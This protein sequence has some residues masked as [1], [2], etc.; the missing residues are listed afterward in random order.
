MPQLDIEL[1]TEAFIRLTEIAIRERRP[2]P[3]QAEVL[4]LQ[5]VGL[6]PVDPAVR[7]GPAEGEVSHAAARD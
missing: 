4:I 7:G 2:N 6:W 3:L 5:G 1:T